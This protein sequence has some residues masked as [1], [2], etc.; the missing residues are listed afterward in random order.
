MG[1]YS[2]TIFPWL[3]D[4]ALGHP[5]IMR[6]RQ[7]LVSQATGEVLEIGFG[8]GATLPF[9]DPAK[10]SSLTVVEPSEGMNRR[11]AARPTCPLHRVRSKPAPRGQASPRRARA[12]G[13]R[14]GTVANSVDA[15][16]CVVSS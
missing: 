12:A 6:R 7:A 9:Y 8:S 15:F 14:K 10:V 2:E 4:K 13:S 1:L 16:A 5:N 11:A 3:L